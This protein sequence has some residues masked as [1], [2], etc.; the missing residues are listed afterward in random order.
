VEP[1]VL[2]KNKAQRRNKDAIRRGDNLTLSRI[3]GGR[4]GATRPEKVPTFELVFS[5]DLLLLGTSHGRLRFMETL[6]GAWF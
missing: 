2:L 6:Y 5:A 3:P 4:L 1:G